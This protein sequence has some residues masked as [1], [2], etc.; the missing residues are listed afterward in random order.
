MDIKWPVSGQV[1]VT[2]LHR[3]HVCSQY[4][5]YHKLKDS[6]SASM[7]CMSLWLSNPLDHGFSWTTEVRF[8]IL[9]NRHCCYAFDAF[10]VLTFYTYV[11][12]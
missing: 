7:C 10:S 12:Y 4:N 3:Q 11:L 5:F 9:H 6:Y 1:Y 8:V 2:I